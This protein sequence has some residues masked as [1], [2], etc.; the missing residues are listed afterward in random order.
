MINTFHLRKDIDFEASC[1]KLV[2]GLLLAEEKVK[3]GTPESYAEAY[4]C[5]SAS[6]SVHLIQCTD[7]GGFDELKQTK[8]EDDIPEELFT[9]HTI[10]SN[11]SNEKL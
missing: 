7:A 9:G 4:G 1:N 10:L 11:N 3:K 8:T 6:V 2:K 5:L